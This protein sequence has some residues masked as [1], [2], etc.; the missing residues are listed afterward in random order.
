M[1]YREYIKFKWVGK[2]VTDI[3]CGKEYGTAW[4]SFF[5]K[6]P[7]LIT[8]AEK[9]TMEIMGV[10]CPCTKLKFIHYSHIKVK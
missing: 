10:T 4:R 2:P 1:K 8:V 3:S 6:R 5:R 9:T 7:L